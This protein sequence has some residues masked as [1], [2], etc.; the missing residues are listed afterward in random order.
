MFTATPLKEN[1]SLTSGILLPNGKEKRAIYWDADERQTGVRSQL[2][3]TCTYRSGGTYW[4]VKFA[5]WK[6]ESYRY[7]GI[8]PRPPSW[9]FG[10][11]FSTTLFPRYITLAK[12]NSFFGVA[13]ENYTTYFELPIRIYPKVAALWAAFLFCIRRIPDSNLGHRINCLEGDVSWFHS[14]PPDE[15]DKTVKQY[16]ADSCLAYFPYFEK[17]KYAYEIIMLSASLCVSPTKFWM[18]DPVF[19]TLRI[20]IMAHES[21]SRV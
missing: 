9:W 3:N 6:T 15:W 4:P 17:L 5:V 12:W 13:D 21:I 1:F 7:H 11:L 20:Y 19:M 10:H 2:G 14:V 16:N 18:P 8:R